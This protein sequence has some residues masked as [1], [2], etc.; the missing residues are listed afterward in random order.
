METAIR[1]AKEKGVL[2]KMAGYRSLSLMAHIP[3]L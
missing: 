1:K 2:W 3:G